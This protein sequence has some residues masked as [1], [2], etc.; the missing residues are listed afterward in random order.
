MGFA[1]T[2]DKVQEIDLVAIDAGK[3]EAWLVVVDQLPWDDDSEGEHLLMLQ[4]KLNGYFA[5]VEHGQL[6]EDFPK[7]VGCKIFFRIDGVHPLSE[8]A[9][10]FLELVAEQ[11][12]ELGELR[13]ERVDVV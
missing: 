13:F 7:A 3:Q 2:V 11:V 1:M 8:Q 6:Y 10:R 5:F 9:E 4:E 12:R